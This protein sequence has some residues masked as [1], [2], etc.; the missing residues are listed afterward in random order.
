MNIQVIT[1]SGS[2]DVVFVDDYNPIEINEQINNSE[3]ITIL[4]G[5]NIYSR[6]DIKSIKPVD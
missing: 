6:I 3:N 1:H 4:L 2:E 5:Q